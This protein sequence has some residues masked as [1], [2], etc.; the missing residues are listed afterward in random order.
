M[1][2]DLGLALGP[3]RGEMA[4]L[5]EDTIRV[6][7]ALDVLAD[8]GDKASR[9]IEAG[10]LRAVRTGRFGF[11][12]LGR[13]A[14]SVMTQIAQS[15]VRSGLDQ[16]FRGG[17]VISFGLDASGGGGAASP[18][19]RIV[20]LLANALGALGLPGRAT[21]GPVSPGR[22]YLVGE[23]GPEVFMPTSSG[24]VMPGAGG[25]G[26][27]DVRVSITVNGSGADA[28]KALARSARQVARAVRGAL[29]E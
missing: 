12:D 25:Q 20:P 24:Q 22:A 4:R 9:A 10:L 2:D 28:P 13:I 27:R 19:A 15:A 7:Q 26:G 23:R 5:Q 21:G 16:L 6:H 1:D 8:A 29:A 14:L 17:P 3:V 11:E 18:V